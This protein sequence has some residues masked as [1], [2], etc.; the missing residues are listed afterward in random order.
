MQQSD[1]NEVLKENDFLGFRSKEWYTEEEF[2]TQADGNFYYEQLA[3]T[4]C[5]YK[6]RSYLQAIAFLATTVEGLQEFC[7]FSAENNIFNISLI[8]SEEGKKILVLYEAT[9]KQ[10]VGSRI[11]SPDSEKED[12]IGTVITEGTGTTLFSNS[13]KLNADKTQQP[14]LFDEHK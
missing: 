3:K 10:L 1:L 12:L 8:D 5:I 6:H 13:D 4:V 14:D 2:E 9:E 11:L 7:N